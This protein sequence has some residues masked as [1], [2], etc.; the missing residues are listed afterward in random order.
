MTDEEYL[1]YE[2]PF[3][4]AARP[5]LEKIKARLVEMGYGPFSEIEVVD[6]D[7]E[8][9]LEI[10]DESNNNGEFA[11]V[12]L[13]LL[14]GD[15]PGFQGVGLVMECSIYASGIVWAPGNWTPD[16]GVTEVDALVQRI[17]SCPVDDVCNSIAHEWEFQ[18]QRRQMAPS[19][20]PGAQG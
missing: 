7:I 10:R 11:F 8:R 19:S 9:G 4:E 20:V 5:L 3:R 1:V 18:R 6:H 15:E 16:V 2:G 13:K 17:E 14:D 12:E